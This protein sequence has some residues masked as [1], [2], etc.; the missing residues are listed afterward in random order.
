MMNYDRFILELM[1]RVSLLEEE[2]AKLKKELKGNG[3]STSGNVLVC[4]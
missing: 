2:V 4:V 1:D 3:D